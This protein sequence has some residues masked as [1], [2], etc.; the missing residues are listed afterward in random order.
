MVTVKSQERDTSK[1]DQIVQRFRQRAFKS[2][3]KVQRFSVTLETTPEEL[4]PLLC[5]AREADWIPGWGCELVYTDSGYAEENCIF[6]TDESN[7][8]GDGL[9]V[10]TGF[11]TNRYVEFV[12]VQKD[13]VTS[14]RITVTD[15]DDGTVTATWNMIS[16]GLTERGSEQV[17]RL[18]DGTHSGA[19]TKMLGHYLKTGKTIKR[20][21]LVLGMVAQGV[22]G[23]FS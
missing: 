16:T 17:D 11:E 2:K 15:N 5:P 6:K 8:F 23:H 21:A 14:A 10:F 20:S 9:W 13:L 18:S 1:S 12:R 19:I 22:K 7:A 4:F 3:R